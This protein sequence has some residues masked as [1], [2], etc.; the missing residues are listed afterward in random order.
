[1]ASDD[2]I[3]QRVIIEGAEGALSELQKLGD[4]GAAAIDKIKAAGDGDFVKGFRQLSPE[5]NKMVDG[6]ANAE[7]ASAK[8]GRSTKLTRTELTTLA[9]LQ[10]PTQGIKKDFQDTEAAAA[11][12]T[13]NTRQLSRTLRG[14]ARVTNIPGIGILA[15]DVRGL[16]ANFGLLIGPAIVGGLGLIA[17]TAAKATQPFQELAFAA[18]QTPQALQTAATAAIAFGG[19]VQKL[20]TALSKIP[21]LAKETAT[22][23][24]AM[25]DASK[26][27]SAVIEK[28]NAS[29]AKHAQQLKQASQSYANFRLQIQLG[30]DPVT[31]LREQ[32]RDLSKSFEEGKIS[33][34]DFTKQNTKLNNQ[35]T[36][37]TR[38]QRQEQA[39]LEEKIREAN[40]AFNDQFEAQLEAERAAVASKRAVEDNA[41]AFVKLGVSSQQLKSLKPGEAFELIAQKLEPM[42]KGF[43]RNQL[44]IEIFGDQARLFINELDKGTGGVAKFVAESQKIAPTFDTAQNAIGDNFLTS[45]GKVT[46]AAGSLKDAF[47]LAV[48]PAF[49]EFFNNLTTIFVGM[50][51]AVKD[52]GDALA[53]VLKP[54]LEG[55]VVII[56]L[57]GS[58]IGVLKDA[59]TIAAQKVNE[60]FGGE[61]LTAGRIFLGLIVLLGL[62]FAPITTAILLTIIAIGLF[63]DAI[64]KVDWKKL[65]D[66]ALKL[67]D[68]AK[69]KI[70]QFIADFFKGLQDLIN[71]ATDPLVKF[72]TDLWAAIKLKFDEGVTFI[73]DSFN[74]GIDFIR[75]KWE[76]FK[77]YL[78]SWVSAVVQFFQ[79]LIDRINKI[80]AFFA[81]D[82][83][84]SSLANDAGLNSFAGGGGVNGAGT[85]TSDSILAWLSNGE[86]VM[87][88]RAVAKYGMGFMKAINSGR[89]D[90]ESLAGFSLGGLVDMMSPSM[91]P[92][93]LPAFAGGGG[94]N[95]PGQGLKPVSINF[96]GTRFDAFMTDHAIDSLSKK[97]VHDRS[98]RAGRSPSW[99]GG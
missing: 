57:V 44:A 48:A 16:S 28:G 77:S 12:L 23:E 55:L 9:G 35:L 29:L 59:F 19:D 5:L 96:E 62:A 17:D 76:A 68:Q 39:D 46:A 85:S 30:L 88:A 91:G 97:S 2:D 37:A 75:G 18:G 6:L 92:L 42:E 51:P 81:S 83:S 24:K 84:R 15:R 73:S 1:M 93:G 63:S 94:V 13:V 8:L 78:Q 7:I 11:S 54:A 80:S 72:F 98:K 50:R 25:A 22:Q 95:I 20:G 69:A 65:V 38:Q 49:T 14:L 82:A 47:G 32:I 66:G 71:Q 89:L 86:F 60:L 45:I 21:S 67:F 74:T 79:P 3:R 36:L 10:K 56:Q 99:V 90:L 41:N 64:K 33:Q 53:G 61:V 34:E 27:V 87:R 58:G 43:K 40:Q 26:N 31:G 70:I 4:Q 52:L